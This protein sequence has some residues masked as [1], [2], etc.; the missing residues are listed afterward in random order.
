M[1]TS[2]TLCNA[3]I[4]CAMTIL[5][6]LLVLVLAGEQSLAQGN[7]V[8]LDEVAARLECH[9]SGHVAGRKLRARRIV[10]VAA[11]IGASNRCVIGRSMRRRH[12][13]CG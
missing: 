13:G 9:V 4:V 7:L 5:N 6:S 12:G 8:A 2:A 1:R 10:A 3:L 11:G